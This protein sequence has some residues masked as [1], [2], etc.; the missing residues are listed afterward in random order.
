[1]E[2]D[3][4]GIRKGLLEIEDGCKETL[5]IEQKKTE[6]G[7]DCDGLLTQRYRD[8]SLA[9]TDAVNGRGQ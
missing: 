9:G 2:G 8:Q 6:R 1:M 7:N 4:P 5:E 3:E